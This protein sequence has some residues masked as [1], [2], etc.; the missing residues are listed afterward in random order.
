M[1]VVLVLIEIKSP[2]SCKANEVGYTMITSFDTP[3]GYFKVG[4]CYEEGKAPWVGELE[5]FN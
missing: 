5:S 1:V 3:R 2:T 4:T